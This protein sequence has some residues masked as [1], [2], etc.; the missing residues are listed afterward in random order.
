MRLRPYTDLDF[1]IIQSWCTDERSHAMWCAN[2]MEYPVTKERFDKLLKEIFERTEDFPFVATTNDG[3]VV[4]FFCYSINHKTNIGFIKF[5]IIDNLVRGKGFG[6]KMIKL[7]VKYAVDITGADAV[8][9][10]VF[11]SNPGAKRCYEKAG[12]TELEVLE[13]TFSYKEEIWF[14]H[15]LRYYKK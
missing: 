12:F 7:A 11:S 13:N 10:I 9:L 4:G 15:K 3:D 1:E 6:T 5:V 8:D 14:R 2:L